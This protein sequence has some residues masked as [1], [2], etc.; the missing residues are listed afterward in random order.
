MYIHTYQPGTCLFNLKG[1][2]TVIP[3][4]KGELKNNYSPK[5]G[6]LV[7]LSILVGWVLLSKCSAQ[8]LYA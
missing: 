2:H 5:L 4:F 3:N 6:H 8:P 1:S 7:P